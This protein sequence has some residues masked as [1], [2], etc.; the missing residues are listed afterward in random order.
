MHNEVEE[1]GVADVVAL[2]HLLFHVVANVVD[3][4]IEFLLA[5]GKF[6]VEFGKLLLVGGGVDLL[7]ER[8]DV[9][10]QLV[11]G[12]FAVVFLFI[13]L[14]HAAQQSVGLVDFAEVVEESDGLDAS[15]LEGP[16]NH[17]FHGEESVANERDDASHHHGDERNHGVH[18]VAAG[19]FHF[20]AAQRG[21]L[22]DGECHQYGREDEVHE[23]VGDEHHAEHNHHQSHDEEWGVLLNALLNLGAGEAEQQRQQDEDNQ[24]RVFHEQPDCHYQE[25]VGDE[26]LHNAHRNHE[27]DESAS[28]QQHRLFAAIVLVVAYASGQ[29]PAYN[30][31]A[32]H[33]G[34]H[35]IEQ[36]E[37]QG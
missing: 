22:P 18:H 37:N 4:G 1:P 14:L 6:G 17:D 30:H 35:H 28:E 33:S 20:A 5:F 23:V 13:H 21:C 3:D 36:D 12:Q 34:H 11:G 24:P 31:L 15:Q 26:V 32:E 16:P 19:Y 27:N 10:V 25:V 9:G 29:Q 8:V 7:L 2:E